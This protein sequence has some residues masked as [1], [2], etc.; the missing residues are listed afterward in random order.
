MLP[1]EEHILMHLLVTKLMEKNNGKRHVVVI[2]NYFILIGVFKE[3]ALQ[4]RYAMGTVQ[5]DRIGILKVMKNTK[6]SN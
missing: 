1:Q 6:E 2:D 5:C 4:R 3:V